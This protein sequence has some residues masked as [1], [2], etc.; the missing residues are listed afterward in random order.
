M[1][2]QRKQKFRGNLRFV[3]GPSFH[4]LREGRSMPTVDRLLSGI[5][6]QGACSV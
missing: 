6:F 1:K 2:D 3:P 4:L 5:F